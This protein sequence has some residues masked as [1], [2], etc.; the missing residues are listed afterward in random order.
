[1]LKFKITKEDEGYSTVAK[2]DNSFVSTQGKNWEDLEKNIKKVVDLYFEDKKEKSF[3]DLS[4]IMDYR[5]KNY[6]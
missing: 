6:A 2:T 5:L 3:I 4:L 1:M